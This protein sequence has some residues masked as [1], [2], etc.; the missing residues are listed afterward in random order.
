MSKIVF[1]VLVWCLTI[2][3]PAFSALVS[4][5]ILDDGSLLR[6]E[7]VSL[8]DGVYTLRS[9]SMGEFK[10]DAYRVSQ[11]RQQRDGQIPAYTAP[12]QA[13]PQ[14][15]GSSEAFKAQVESTQAALMNDPE[16]MKEMIILASDPAFKK[17]FEDP[18]TVAALKSG[19]MATLLKNPQFLAIMA[20]PKMQGVANRLM[21][22]SKDPQ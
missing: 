16:A 13:D 4:D 3:V 10:L 11:I 12:A 8:Q 1:F 2:V 14:F 18:V 7:I 21:N 22:K 15:S 17:L 6:A 5:I 19:D 9:E 20:D